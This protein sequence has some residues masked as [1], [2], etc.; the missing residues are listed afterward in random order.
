MTRA[1]RER[2]QGGSL[3]AALP[4]HQRSGG[5]LDQGAVF[6][7]LGGAGEPV[8]HRERHFGLREGQAK[9]R[10]G[11]M[12]SASQQR[13]VRCVLLGCPAVQLSIFR[14]AWFFLRE[15]GAC[16][17]GWGQ[18]DGTLGGA[19]QT[20]GQDAQDAQGFLGASG[21]PGLWLRWQ[22]QQGTGTAHLRL[23][24]LRHKASS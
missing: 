18:Q 2:T 24:S 17:G 6:Q 15:T 22:G 19:P 12:L 16:A 8:G 23:L 20:A 11:R 3:V 9:A 1:S 13:G 5:H 10:R 7:V 4:F 14:E 21:R